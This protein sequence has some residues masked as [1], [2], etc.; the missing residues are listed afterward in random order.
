MKKY[1][2]INLWFLSIKSW[3]CSMNNMWGYFS[4]DF[5]KIPFVSAILSRRIVQFK[6][7]GNKPV[8]TIIILLLFCWNVVAIEIIPWAI[9][10]GWSLSML[11]IPQLIMTYLIVGGRH[12]FLALH[13]TCWVLSPPIPQFIALYFVK[14]RFHIFR[15]LINPFIIESPIK[16]N[17]LFE[18]LI[19]SHDFY[20]WYTTLISVGGL[21]LL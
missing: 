12:K 5:F 2:V 6:S 3:S 18:F 8:I 13:R 20:V 1:L 10:F 19:I 17:S 9:S 15:Y 4:H 7:L 16:I 21:L 11:F 14:N